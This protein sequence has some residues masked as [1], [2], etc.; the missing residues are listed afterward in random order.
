[1][2]NLKELICQAFCAEVEAKAIQNGYAVAT[3]Y[4]NRMGDRIGIYAIGERGGPYRLIDT[5]LNVAYLQADGATLDNPTRRQN[6]FSLLNEYGAA[7][8]PELGEIYVPDVQESDLPRKINHFS[9]MLL[10]LNDMIWTT[11]ERTRST[12]RDDVR[13]ALKAELADKVTIKEDKPVSEK[14]SEVTPDMVFWAPGRDPVALFIATDETKLWQ[15]MHLRL[16]ADHEANEPVVVIALLQN[17]NALSRGTVTKADNRLDA[18]PRYEDEPK[19]ALNR[20]FREVIGKP[21]HPLQ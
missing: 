7:Y 16:V 11:T 8:D 9:A 19:A 3:P 10:R 1:M 6:F 2:V 18:I 13:A 14:L 5:A 17:Q 4:E 21:Q 12:F 15:A 20:I